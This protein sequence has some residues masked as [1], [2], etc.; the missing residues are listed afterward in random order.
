MTLA[1]R[2]I[3][4]APAAMT[5]PNQLSVIIAT[6]CARSGREILTYGGVSN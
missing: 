5:I 4:S 2:A 6:H 1:Y 3:L